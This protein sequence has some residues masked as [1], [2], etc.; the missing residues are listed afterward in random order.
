MR[1]L[2]LSLLLASIASGVA[3]NNYQL[4]YLRHRGNILILQCTA[5]NYSSAENASFWINETER[6]D[7]LNGLQ[8]KD[9]AA[10]I[11][12]EDV[13]TNA[14]SFVLRPQYE[15]TFYCGEIDGESSNGLGPMAGDCYY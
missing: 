5:L 15:G 7:I 2:L 1:S 8:V 11:S 10:R 13:M 3:S 6:I 12:T 14:V 4:K 9:A